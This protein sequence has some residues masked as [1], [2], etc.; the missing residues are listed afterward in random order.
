M[1]N[2]LVIELTQESRTSEFYFSDLNAAWIA[3]C[4]LNNVLIPAHFNI[5][6]LYLHTNESFVH[7]RGSAGIYQRKDPLTRDVL[8][9]HLGH[10]PS[11]FLD[12]HLEVKTWALGHEQD[13]GSSFASH[14]P[15]QEVALGSMSLYITAPHWVLRLNCIHPLPTL[16]REYYPLP[17]NP[18]QP[19]QR[20]YDPPK[21]TK[22]L[23]VILRGT[24]GSF[25]PLSS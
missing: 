14:V 23:R 19:S 6:C 18:R 8:Y 16:L 13:E 24:L 1:F 20:E 11:L 15:R 9:E 3:F 7:Q 22:F 5:F 21:V 10:K 4:S 2:R 25:L 12:R 17:R